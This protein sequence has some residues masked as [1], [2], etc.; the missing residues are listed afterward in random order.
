M[1]NE[2]KL[3]SDIPVSVNHYLGYRAVPQKKNGKTFYLVMPYVTKEAKDYK[4]KFSEYA[5]I[6]VEEQKWD[7][8]Q[9]RERHH[10]MDCVF[11][12]PRTDQDEQNYF[13]IMC[14]SIN[15][16][17]YVDDRKILTRTPRIFY[18]SVNPRV[19]IIISPVD[20]IGIFDN[21]LIL[22][23]FEENCKT[24]S[25]YKNNCS[26][27]VKAK[28]G[29]IQEDITGSGLDIKCEKYKMIKLK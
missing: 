12:F 11:Y 8:E 9:T 14:D 10:Y 21:E 4:K 27:L 13:K 20:Y 24:C 7:I 19:E 5:K 16:I 6:Q 3:V 22:S 29:R 25:R 28:E 26:I 2:L 23:E 17:A 1:K 15:E 18:D